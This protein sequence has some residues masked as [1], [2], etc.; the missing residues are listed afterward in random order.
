MEET[1]ITVVQRT[2]DIA[3]SDTENE[4]KMT[5]GAFTT[6]NDFTYFFVTT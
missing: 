5:S 1:I 3:R 6:G 4:S 2:P